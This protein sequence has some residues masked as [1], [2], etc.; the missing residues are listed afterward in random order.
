M[1]H[2]NLETDDVPRGG[3]MLEYNPKYDYHDMANK[4]LYL[5]GNEVFMESYFDYRIPSNETIN[6][7]LAPVILEIKTVEK[8]SEHQMGAES[9][10]FLYDFLQA[11][12][13]LVLKP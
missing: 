8:S 3:M 12:M 11:L 13:S 6:T 2:W 10:S 1:K 4:T 9:F 7:T 5:P